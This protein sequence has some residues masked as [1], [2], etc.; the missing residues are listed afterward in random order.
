MG[1][2]RQIFQRGEHSG[3]SRHY[4]YKG[5][6]LETPCVACKDNITRTIFACFYGA[7]SKPLIQPT[8][9]FTTRRH[10][11]SISMHHDEPLFVAIVES[12]TLRITI[13]RT[14]KSS[15]NYI[16]H[17]GRFGVFDCCVWVGLPLVDVL[18]CC[19]LQHDRFAGPCALIS[20]LFYCR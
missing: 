4:R 20:L 19:Y 13:N 5:R 3:E 15:H 17:A 8:G 2:V 6:K 1:L 11:M 10:A 16:M 12:I 14:Q 9:K 18:S 7:K